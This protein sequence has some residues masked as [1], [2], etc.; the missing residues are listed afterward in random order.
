MALFL[1]LLILSFIITCIAIIPF[2]NLLY[3]LKF[4]RRSELP[5]KGKVPLAD[6]L[7][8]WKVGTPV[9]GGILIIVVVSLLYFFLFPILQYLGVYITAVY[10]LKDELNIIFFTFIAFGLLGLYDDLIKF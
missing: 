10:P 9:G 5:K 7:H 8:H 3:R 4:T 6:K 1:G 2:I